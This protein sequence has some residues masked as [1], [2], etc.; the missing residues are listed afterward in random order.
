MLRSISAATILFP[1]FVHLLCGCYVHNM[2]LKSLFAKLVSVAAMDVETGYDHPDKVY[3]F[4][5]IPPGMVKCED[6]Y[7]RCVC[8]YRSINIPKR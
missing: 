4:N 3:F 8:A 2:L 6:S 5:H 1:L 7:W